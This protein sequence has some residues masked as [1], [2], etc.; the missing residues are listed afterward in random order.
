MQNLNEQSKLT[1]V[2]FT[3]NNWTEEELTKLR[4]DGRFSYICWGK[5]LAP[6]S[7]TPHLQGY[8]ELKSQ[9]RFNVVSKWYRW[10]IERRKAASSQPAIDYCKKD[11]E[12]E[13]RGTPKDAR[14]T[15]QGKRK[16]LDVIR[17][18]LQ[19]GGNMRSI[20]SISSSYQGLKAAE[21]YLKY[22]EPPRTWFTRV[23]YIWGKPRIGKSREAYRL[24][25]GRDLY[26]KTT[27]DKW[28]DGYDG[29]S[30]VIF[31]D[32]RDTWLAL[33]HFL[34]IC[35]RYECKVETKGGMRQFK[36][37]LLIIT[38]VFSPEEIYGHAKGEPRE[39]ITGRIAEVIHMEAPLVTPIDLGGVQIEDFINVWQEPTENNNFNFFE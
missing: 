6:T 27:P 23:V 5:E 18:E 13:E 30:T 11:A 25:E 14:G 38:T 16:D 26:V 35:D 24:A 29:H 2:C 21:L 39:Q 15:G 12:F 32:F 1:N 33:S 7:G 3:L 4:E 9:T 34:A 28:F 8:F 22:L 36:P 17:E 20:C 31:D 37:E 19:N 10:H